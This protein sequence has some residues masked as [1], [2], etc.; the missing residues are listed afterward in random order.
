MKRASVLGTLL[1]V[2]LLTFGLQA[3]DV[4][5]TTPKPGLRILGTGEIRVSPDLA[6]VNMNVKTTDM[7]FNRAVQKLNEKTD[8]LYK[9]LQSS[10]FRKDEIKTSQLNVQENGQWRDGNYIDSGFVATQN[11]ELGFKR[12][13][14][15][16]ARLME[17]F[18]EEK[19]AEAL[20]HFG[21]A[22]SDEAEQKAKDE[23]V[24]KAIQDARNKATLI[25]RASGVKLGKVRNI[26]YGQPDIR[27]VPMMEAAYMDANMRSAKGQSMPDIE[28]QEIQ[29]QDTITIFWEIE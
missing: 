9:K 18:S 23:L 24:G 25:A 20:F 21:F 27:P 26:V 19:G 4:S 15:R 12:D 7:D 28:V 14:A 22:L 1:G 13:H 10:G 29:M 6:V 11:I 16:M 2:I 5:T 17:A 3:Q 8:H